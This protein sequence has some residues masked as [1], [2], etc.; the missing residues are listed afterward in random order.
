MMND[1]GISI[2][3]RVGVAI[4]IW[5]IGI[6]PALLAIGVTLLMIKWIFF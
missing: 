5:I 6:V 1:D 3:I 2:W 4:V